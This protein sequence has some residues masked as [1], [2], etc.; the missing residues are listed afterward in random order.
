MKK[1]FLGHLEE[2]RKRVKIC[3]ILWMLGTVVI[4]PFS[5]SILNKMKEFFLPREWRLIITSPL[6][7]IVG[8]IVISMLFSFL[9]TLPLILHQLLGFIYPALTKREKK[10][11]W[12]L[13][14]MS[15]LLTSTGILFSFFIFLPLT[16]KVLAF[17]TYPVEVTPLITLMSFLKFVIL[18]TF[19]VSLLFNLPI[20]LL[21]LE[22]LG[23]I[24]HTSL[25][26][27]RKYM[28]IATLI[29]ISILTPDPTPL[30]TVVLL[31]PVWLIYELSIWLMKKKNIRG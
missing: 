16:F 31:I 3:V 2:L 9:L 5:H 12:K 29:I 20:L 24:H 8:E 23:V 28:F 27:N 15:I 21:F 30:S 17:L 26:K 7:I 22:K 4:F 18:S 25:E 19:F 6:E 13:F 10:L 1:T 11:F 14:P